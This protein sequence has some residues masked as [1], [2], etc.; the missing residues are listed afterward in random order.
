MSS[1]DLNPVKKDELSSIISDSDL[2]QKIH[3]YGYTEIK[4]NDNCEC[5]DGIPYFFLLNLSSSKNFFG[6]DGLYC[7]K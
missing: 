2:I 6:L 5:P 1:P 4:K 3:I 7:L